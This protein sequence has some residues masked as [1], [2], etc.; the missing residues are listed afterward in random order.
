MIRFLK[1]AVG[2]LKR[3]K[4]SSLRVLI[5]KSITYALATALAPFHLRR[6]TRVGAR[7]RTLG[8]APRIVNYGTLTIGDDVRISSHVTP[9]ELV[10]Y[11]GAELTIGEGSH[12]NYGVSIGATKSITVGARARI[13][14]Y[15]RIVDSDFHDVYN[16]A[17]PAEPKPVVIGEDAWLGMHVIVL[18]GVRIGKAAVIGSGSVVTKDVPP[19]T[20]AGG[21]PAKVLRELDPARFVADVTARVGT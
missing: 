20:V 2:K 4:N 21:V 13:G 1:V 8:G 11:E 3:D 17:Q 19:F 10:V 15:T 16:R 14:P 7:V 5:D 9:V 12:I 6:A 18:P